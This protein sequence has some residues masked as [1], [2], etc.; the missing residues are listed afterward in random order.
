MM[1]ILG[2]SWRFEQLT[3][4]GVYA[5]AEARESFLILKGDSDLFFEVLRD[6]LRELPIDLVD[7]SRLSDF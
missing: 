5:S 3:S 2:S 4:L 6:I 7:L 1:S